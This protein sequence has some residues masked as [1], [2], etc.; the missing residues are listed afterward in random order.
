MMEV[1]MRM[2]AIAVL[3]LLGGGAAE[4]AG[5]QMAMGP[6]PGGKLG[7]DMP[8][9]GDDVVR[10]APAATAEREGRAPAPPCPG[11]ANAP[12]SPSSER[13]GKDCPPP[14]AGSSSEPAQAGSSR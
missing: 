2:V 12:G 9:Q 14:D 4:A 1:V 5:W 3:V 11:G 8:F 13:D 6:N 7:E 10:R